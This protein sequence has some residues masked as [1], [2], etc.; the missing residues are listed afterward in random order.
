MSSARV[1]VVD[2]AM[3][4][5]LLV[6]ETEAEAEAMGGGIMVVVG[7]GDEEVVLFAGG[8]ALDFWKRSKSRVRVVLEPGEGCWVHA[9]LRA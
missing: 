5:V 6:G 2:R 4:R 1:R 3:A 8:L 7:L 9:R